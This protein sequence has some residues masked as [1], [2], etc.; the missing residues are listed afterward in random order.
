MNIKEKKYT[1]LNKEIKSLVSSE[2][3]FIAN[4][5]NVCAAIKTKF[6]YEKKDY[7]KIFDDQLFILFNK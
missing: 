4:L 1:L 3:N 6:N 5:A 2:T 7:K